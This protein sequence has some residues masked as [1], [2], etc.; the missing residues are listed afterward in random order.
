MY[1]FKN[2]LLPVILFVSLFS[3]NKKR[4]GKPERSYLTMS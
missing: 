4:P 1:S 2:T 3:M